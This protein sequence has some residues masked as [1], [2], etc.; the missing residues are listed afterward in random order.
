[1]TTAQRN[2]SGDYQLIRADKLFKSFNGLQVI[3]RLV[4]SYPAYKHDDIFNFEWIFV[5]NLLK[6][7]AT[8]Q[9]INS[10][11]QELAKK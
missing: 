10:K 4:K 2:A 6:L 9:Y 3:D 5:H 11:M 8:N 7:D 1:M